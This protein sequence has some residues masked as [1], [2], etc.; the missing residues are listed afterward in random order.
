MQYKEFKSDP[1]EAVFVVNR[2]GVHPLWN[3]WLVRVY[4]LTT[5]LGTELHIYLQGA[6]HE[7]IVQ[8][9][10]PDFEVPEKID[11][12]NYQFNL[13]DPPEHAYQFISV[14]D[15]SAFYRIFLACIDI[16]SGELNPDKDGRHQ[17][18][19]LFSDGRT[20]RK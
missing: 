10:N 17:W 18:D 2:T 4:D 16:E 19:E 3:N 5:D 7:V 9:L 13:L 1:W 14:D 12:D 11:F 15:D 20:L 6:T 8:A